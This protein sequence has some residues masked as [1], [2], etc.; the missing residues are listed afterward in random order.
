[1][2]T[3]R[4]AARVGAWVCFLWLCGLGSPTQAAGLAAETYTLR[5]GLRV[6]L[7][8]DHRLPL[9]FLRVRYLAGSARDPPGRTGLAHLLEHLLFEGSS[10]VVSP[11]SSYRQANARGVNASTGRD[12]I[13]CYALLPAGNEATGLFIESDRMRFLW[14]MLRREVLLKSVRGIV[15]SERGEVLE[16]QPIETALEQLYAQLF[17]AGHPYHHLPIGA[18]EDLDRISAGDLREFYGRQFAPS[19]AVL[20]LVG[21]LNPATLRPL[22]ERY[23]GTLPGGAKIVSFWLTRRYS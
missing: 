20:A 18:S 10:N 12:F 13:D 17:P 3:T 1:M 19:N 2:K 9:V 5:N 8:E 14:P 16:A 23:F 6:V 11:S 21:D 4:L 7:H 15:R 22:I